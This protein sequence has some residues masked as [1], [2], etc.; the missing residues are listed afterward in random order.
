[1]GCK[2]LGGGSDRLGESVAA[3]S[4]RRYPPPLQI[5]LVP[6]EA[7]HTRAKNTNLYACKRLLV[8]HDQHSTGWADTKGRAEFQTMKGRGILTRIEPPPPDVLLVQPK[9]IGNDVR[10]IVPH[11]E[12]VLAF[13][14]DTLHELRL[15]GGSV[16]DVD[17]HGRGVRA[18]PQA[19]TASANRR[20]LVFRF[21]GKVAP[22]TP[23]SGETWTSNSTMC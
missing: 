10:E 20:F 15:G 6:H 14:E 21:E 22:R 2:G 12:A 5:L 4:H 19:L 8:Y 16:C 17:L 23:E 9:F 1:M 13:S 7:C 11:V 18:L 3:G